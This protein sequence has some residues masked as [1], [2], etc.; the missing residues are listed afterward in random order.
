MAG[1][2][3]RTPPSRDPSQHRSP[4]LPDVPSTDPPS[5]SIP[6]TLLGTD[7]WDT[8]QH[9]PSSSQTPGTSIHNR[10]PS[11]SDP[12][13]PS[14]RRRRLRARDAPRPDTQVNGG[15]GGERSGAG[16]SGAHVRWER[17]GG[18]HEA[19]PAGASPA[20]RESLFGGAGRVSPASWGLPGV[21]ESPRGA[22]WDPPHPSRPCRV[23]GAGQP[24]ASSTP[25]ASPP[26]AAHPH[27][28]WLGWTPRTWKKQP[29]GGRFISEASPVSPLGPWAAALMW[30]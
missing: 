2:A 22:V 27:R 15:G 6:R 9:R 16:A 30:R 5:A 18:G 10:P 14:Q 1:A 26:G 28:G 11:A 7:P 21:A 24:R 20:R 23:R 19:N 12:R 3:V 13:D 25:G 4:G 29:G 8:P 17:W